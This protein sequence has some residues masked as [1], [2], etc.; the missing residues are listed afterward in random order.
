L[1]NRPTLSPEQRLKVPRTFKKNGK[2]L[3]F[4]HTAQKTVLDCKASLK[5]VEIQNSGSQQIGI[6]PEQFKNCKLF[7]KFLNLKKVLKF[8]K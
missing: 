6:N 2:S 7:I 3:N 1:Q 4:F 8:Y 5:R